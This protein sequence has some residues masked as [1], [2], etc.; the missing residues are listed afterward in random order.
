MTPDPKVTQ[1]V[2]KP[3]RGLRTFAA[4]LE[5]GRA[6]KQPTGTAAPK[7]TAPK[8]QVKLAAPDEKNSVYEAPKW[9]KAP[10]PEEK[11]PPVEEVESMPLPAPLPPRH[12]TRDRIIVDNPDAAEATIIRDTKKDRFRLFPAIWTSLKQKFENFKANRKQKQVPKYIVPEASLRKGVIQRA[13]SQTGKVT[14]LDYESLQDRIK[15]REERIK[16]QPKTDTTPA[17]TPP[18][19]SSGWVT[20]KDEDEPQVI[21]TALTEPGYPLLEGPD[22]TPRLTVSNVRIEPKRSLER[23]KPKETLPAPLRQNEPIV[24]K[25]KKLVPPPEPAPAVSKTAPTLNKTILP[26]KPKPAPS[27]APQASAPPKSTPPVAIRPMP[28]KPVVL[29]SRVGLVTSPPPPPVIRSAPKPPDIPKE[30]VV[31]PAEKIPEPTPSVIPTA[32]ITTPVTSSVPRT[33][34]PVVAQPLPEDNLYI[35]PEVA[36]PV[37]PDTAIPKNRGTLKERLLN[38]NTNQLALGLTVLVAAISIFGFGGY[39]WYSSLVSNLSISAGPQYP[40]LLN[41]HIQALTISQID[42]QNLIT[43]VTDNNDNNS[44]GALQ[45]AFVSGD[46]GRALIPPA[47]IL[48][49]LKVPIVPGFVPTVT[50]IYFGSFDPN[51]PFIVM[52][53]TDYDTARGSLL[54]WEETLYSDFGPLLKLDATEKNTSNFGDVVVGGIDVRSLK[55]TGLQELLTYGIVNRN[56][57]II[58][59]NRDD[60]AQVAELVI[61]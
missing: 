11:K 8:A 27:V 16:P 44:R 6:K 4:D 46:K 34:E 17:P 33:P 49:G 22:L 29:T 40:Q 41:A 54:R 53:V 7:A 3:I 56:T 10:P 48:Q 1:T 15:A 30:P 26:T 32:P 21:W 57:I 31:V 61:K 19:P 37:P 50:A 20:E 39:I 43:A 51:R 5:R 23:N 14:D 58:T 60:F 45:L 59:R 35:E 36:T 38:Y 12:T 24:A 18:Q 25:P 2:K 55:A 52:K 47:I 9:T 28:D 13:T 42:R